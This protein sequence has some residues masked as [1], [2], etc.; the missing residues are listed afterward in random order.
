MPVGSAIIARM[1]RVRRSHSPSTARSTLPAWLVFVIGVLAYLPT[2][3]HDFVWDDVNFIVENP[4]SHSLGALPQS[5]SKGYG[6]VPIEETGPDAS[7]YFRPLVTA[8]NTLHWVLANGRPG[9]FHFANAIAHGVT[10]AALVLFALELRLAAPAAFLAGALFAVHPVNTEAV[11]WISGRTDVFAACFALVCLWLLAR[12]MRGATPPALPAGAFFLAFASKESALALLV[13]APLLVLL[14]PDDTGSPTPTLTDAVRR[15]LGPR[16]RGR[17]ALI[18]LGIAFL[19]YAV[20]RIGVLE[21]GAFGG[22][23]AIAGRGTLDTRFVQGGALFATYLLRIFWPSSLS[24]EPPSSVTL[25]MLDRGL[26][27]LGL[28]L[29]AAGGIGVFLS[30]RRAL[31]GRGSPA[32]AIGGALFLVGVLPV[33]QWIPTG[34]IYG[35]RFMYLPAAGLLLVL[36]GLAAPLLG[37][38]PAPSATVAILLGIPLLFVLERRLPDWRTEIALFESAVRADATSA[39]ALANLGSAHMKAGRLDVAEPYL[40]KARSKDPEDPQKRAQY[41]SLLVNTGRVDEG[42]LELEWAY[43]RGRHTRTLLK[44]LGIGWTRQGRGEDASR[45]LAQARAL[46]PN[47]PGILEALAMARRKAG[48]YEEAARLF[49]TA[50]GLDRERR[51]CYL[52]LLSLQWNELRDAAGARRTAELFLQR[53]PA[54]PEAAQVRAMLAGQP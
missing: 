21:E 53:F 19:V 17:R 20:F 4:L 5:L 32:I 11:A 48:S 12:A 34:E 39:R 14:R 47:D 43:E 30:C 10:A 22:R 29:L 41:G 24:V 8:A 54:A 36:I 25:A 26:G 49:E 40:A 23:N 13:V 44:N 37:S 42:V 9:F 46:A 18:A 50:L 52:N 35:E 15:N 31:A 3:S 6:W 51:G 33:L 1:T 2:L 27:L 16:S 38:K 45:V 28:L 7:L